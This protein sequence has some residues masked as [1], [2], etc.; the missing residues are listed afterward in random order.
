MI[1]VYLPHFDQGI[2]CYRDH[3]LMFEHVIRDP[4][5]VGSVVGL[6]Y[7]NVH[8]GGGGDKEW[9]SWKCTML[10]L[11]H[12]ELWYLDPVTLCAVETCTLHWTTS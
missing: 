6:K 3:L 2:D 1:G 7:F 10:V 12:K 4:Q 8:L 11:S 5:L 9:K